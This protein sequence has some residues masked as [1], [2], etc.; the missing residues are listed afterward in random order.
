MAIIT[1]YKSATVD[2]GA[3]GA[4]ITDGGID[5]LLPAITSQNRLA[6]LTFHRKIWIQSDT[7]LTILTSLANE[8]QYD[9][10]W[11]TSANPLTDTV[12]NLTGIETKYG[13]M[14]IVSNT[15]TTATV[16]N[17]A[18]DIL[19]RVNDYAYIGSDVVQISA[20][21]DNGDGTSTITFSPAIATA[22]HSGTM[23]STLIS[24]A[25]TANTAVP[26]W[27]KV[28]IPPLAP[29]SSNYNTLQFLTVY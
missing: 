19:A 26:F 22:D 16:T 8:G 9:A 2:G 23:F 14:N 24:S 25:F 18:T 15:T 29:I 1:Y 20:I 17:D 27:I 5:D 4:Q 10:T 12:A 28:V 11:F 3:I 6:G 13:A 7:T 21:V